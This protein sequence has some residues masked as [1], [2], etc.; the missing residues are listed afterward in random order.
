MRIT[1]RQ[2][3]QERGRNVEVTLENI[4]SSVMTYLDVPDRVERILGSFLRRVDSNLMGEI[5]ICYSVNLA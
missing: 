4:C 5:S 3:F 2:E 1:A